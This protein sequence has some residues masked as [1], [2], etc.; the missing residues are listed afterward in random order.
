MIVNLEQGALEGGE[1]RSLTTG[2]KFYTFYGIP[3]GEPPVGEL[4][5]RV[6]DLN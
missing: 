5:F 4:R 3:Y 1:D 6:R 2:R